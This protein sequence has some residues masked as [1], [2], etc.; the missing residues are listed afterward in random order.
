MG[1]KVAIF[2]MN[3]EK[4][5]AVAS[6]HGSTFCNVDVT[7]DDS[8]DADFKG[9]ARAADG[10]ETYPDKLCWQVRRTPR[11]GRKAMARSGI[12]DGCL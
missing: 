8:V 11:A 9:P 10:Q 4:G 3:E 12:S 2:D 1:G 6:E 5:Q 7:S